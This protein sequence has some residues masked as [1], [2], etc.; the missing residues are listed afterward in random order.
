MGCIGVYSCVWL[1]LLFLS[2]YFHFFFHFFFSKWSDVKIAMVV[3]W[4]AFAF[5]SFPLFLSFF[6]FSFLVK[7]LFLS[8]T[9][10]HFY[11]LVP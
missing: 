6:L 9:I 11:V 3:T 4:L 10:W 2:D 8:D 5:P 1:Y 7:L